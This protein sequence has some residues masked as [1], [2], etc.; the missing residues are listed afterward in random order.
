MIVPLPDDNP[1]LAISLNAAYLDS[2]YVDFSQGSGYEEG[3]GIFSGNLDFT[4][5]E[6]VRAPKLSAGMSIVQSLLLGMDHE[7]EFGFSGY[8]NSG[9]YY[10]AQNTV[11]EPEFLTIGSRIGYVY[12][13]WDMRLTAFVKN[14]LNEK[15]NI[16]KFQTD[17][18]VNTTLAPPRQY[19]M[20]VEWTY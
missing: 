4:G 1:G 8:Y 14:A 7:L 9:F 13:P 5:N 18:G 12:L 11:E 6:I 17:F 3:S 16:A 20:R 15:H 19:G 2:E 10:T